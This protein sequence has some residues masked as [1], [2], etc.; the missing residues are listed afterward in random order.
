VG[1]LTLQWYIPILEGVCL[2]LAAMA[3]HEAAHVLVALAIGIKVKRIGLEWKGLYTIRDPGPPLKNL[4]VTLA[5]PLM[6]A[7]LIVSWH[8]WPVFGLANLIFAVVNLL[9]IA[10]SDGLRVAHCWRE[11]HEKRLLVG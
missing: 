9:P 3:V 4:V 2:G 1:I 7:I 6:N 11:M 5:G 10:G 8:W